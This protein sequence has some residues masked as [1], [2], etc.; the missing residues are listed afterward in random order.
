MISKLRSIGSAGLQHVGRNKGR[1]GKGAGAAGVAGLGGMI[2]YSAYQN[3]STPSPGEALVDLLREIW[4]PALAVG[5]G[6][7]AIGGLMSSRVTRPHE[8]STERRHRILRN[9]ALSAGLGGAS[10]VALPAGY[11]LLTTPTNPGGGSFLRN[12]TDPAGAGLKALAGSLGGAAAGAALVRYKPFN[13]GLGLAARNR[14]VADAANSSLTSV[15]RG[16]HMKNTSPIDNLLRGAAS[17]KTN[18]S[19]EEL[20]LLEKLK[21]GQSLFRTMAD[22]VSRIPSERLAS[23]LASGAPFRGSSY[24]KPVADALKASG[25]RSL[26]SADDVARLQTLAMQSGRMQ[27]PGSGVLSYL[28]NSTRFLNPFRSARGGGPM[29]TAYDASGNVV[30]TLNPTAQALAYTGG[31][32]LGYTVQNSA[33]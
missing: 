29:H 23:V 15:A 26:S 22:P 28:Q 18:I 32:G 10:A 16:L 14:A 4:L 3:A 33:Y 30:R 9:A 13:I 24:S 21:S 2:G 19:L 5:A 25:M 12:I 6:S 27:Y 20:D 31:A 11:R 7:G 1:Y 17:K 8:S